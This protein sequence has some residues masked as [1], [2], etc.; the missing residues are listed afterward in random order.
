MEY[1]SI[2]KW[3]LEDGRG[4]STPEWESFSKFVKAVYLAEQCGIVDPRLIR[5]DNKEGYAVIT[6][7]ELL[8]LDKWADELLALGG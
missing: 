7:E 4:S 5:V 8:R 3:L 1:K 6:E 2:S